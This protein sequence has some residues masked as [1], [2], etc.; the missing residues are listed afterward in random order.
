MKSKEGGIEKCIMLAM[1]NLGVNDD[2]I[3]KFAGVCLVLSCT[4]APLWRDFCSGKC[5]TVDQRAQTGFQKAVAYIDDLGKWQSD[6][7]RGWL[8]E[9]VVAEIKCYGCDDP[10]MRLSKK[11]LSKLPGPPSIYDE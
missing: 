9:K 6:T 8:E 7:K 10:S 5:G 2:D 3:H 4:N 11:Q 1:K